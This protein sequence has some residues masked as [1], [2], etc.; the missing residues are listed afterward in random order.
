M[1][2]HRA[3]DSITNGQSISKYPFGVFK[4]TKK[5]TKSLKDFCSSLKK[6][7][8]IKKAPHKIMFK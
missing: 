4:S 1:Q 7:V 2:F 8:K 5:P 6:E 3:S